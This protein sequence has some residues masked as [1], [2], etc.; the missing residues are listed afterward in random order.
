MRLFC[1]NQPI[2]VVRLPIHFF[3]FEDFRWSF[4][5]KIIGQKQLLPLPSSSSI[6]IA[7]ALLLKQEKKDDLSL[8]TTFLHVS[9]VTF[10]CNFM[11][12]NLDI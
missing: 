3:Y 10:K 12:F 2:F 4:F 9:P 8:Q 5:G 7:L 6:F 1:E 11:T